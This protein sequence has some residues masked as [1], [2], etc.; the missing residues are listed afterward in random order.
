LKAADRSAVQT[1]LELH[2]PPAALEA[3]QCRMTSVVYSDA[4]FEISAQL[5]PVL[6]LAMVVEEKLQPD[7]EETP[8]DRVTRSWL[9]VSLVLGEMLA[10]SVVAGGLSPSEGAGSLIALSMLFAAFLMALPVI[11]RELQ[12]GRGRRERF[13]HALAGLAV[14]VAVLSTIIAIQLS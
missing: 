5:I 11:S 3:C 10:L 2:W 4:Y 6:F 14:L 9:F 12:E 1:S 8:G 7:S 13:G